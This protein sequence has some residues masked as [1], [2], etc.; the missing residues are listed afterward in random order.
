[1]RKSL[2]IVFLCLLMFGGCKTY[3]TMNDYYNACVND[4]Q[5]HARMLALSGNVSSSVVSTVSSVGILSPFS[6]VLGTLSGFIAALL[7]GIMYGKKLR[8][9]RTDDK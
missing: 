8:V 9:V 3:Q 7:A 4:Q 2:A 6:G 5:C 1:M